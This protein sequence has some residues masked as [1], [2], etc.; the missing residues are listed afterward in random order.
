MPRIMFDSFS[1]VALPCWEDISG[2]VESDER[3]FTLA[4]GDGIGALQFSV[5][6]Y[7]EGLVPD[8]SPHDLSE[9]VAAFAEARGLGAPREVIVE[10]V[11]LR[12][13]AGSFAL[14]E[15]FLRVWQVSDGR[16]FAFVT[17]TCESGQQHRELGE[18]ERIVRSL[19][20]QRGGHD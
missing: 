14:G 2:S 5:A 12:L 16:N 6:R 15:D 17:Y 20:F 1:V 18:C 4:R 13:A 7:T 19:L 10:S 8:P 3:C 11:P 9:M